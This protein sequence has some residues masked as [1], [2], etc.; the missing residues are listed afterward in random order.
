MRLDTSYRNGGTALSSEHAVCRTLQTLLP[1]LTS[2]VLWPSSKIK[3]FMLCLHGSISYV[4]V[5]L[6]FLELQ[7]AVPT[8]IPLVSSARSHSLPLPLGEL[9]HTG[10]VVFCFTRFFFL[11]SALD[12]ETTL[13]Y[14]ISSLNLAQAPG[15]LYISLNWDKSCNWGAM[16]NW[17]CCWSRRIECNQYPHMLE[18]PSPLSSILY[19]R[20]NFEKP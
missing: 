15:V 5:G 16:P 3:Q 4:V 9:T 11:F 18:K 7:T 17:I 19:V 2:T 14:W 10:L 6:A 20:Y 1:M 13:H 12:K 8:A